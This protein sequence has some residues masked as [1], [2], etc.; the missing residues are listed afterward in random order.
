MLGYVYDPWTNP[1]PIPKKFKR[2]RKI[3]KPPKKKDDQKDVVK[4]VSGSN[5]AAEL[6]KNEINNNLP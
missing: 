5:I 1:N 6:I 2:I 3:P 4:I